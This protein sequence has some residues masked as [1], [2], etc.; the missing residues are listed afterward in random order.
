MQRHELTRRLF[1]QMAEFKRV[2]HTHFLHSF[3]KLG[4]SPTQLQLL[5]T[6]K[7]TQ[8]VSPKQLAAKMQL[9][10]SAISQVLDGLDSAGYITRTPSQTD[11]RIVNLSLSPIGTRKLE[12]LDQQREALLTEA[13]AALSDQELELWLHVQRKLIDSFEQSANNAK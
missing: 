3:E 4:L 6:I 9:S 11:R 12:D 5:T 8:P 13:F 7:F 10:P 1:E 2:G